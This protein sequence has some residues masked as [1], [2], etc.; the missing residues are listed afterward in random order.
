MAVETRSM[1]GRIVREKDGETVASGWCLIC[2]DTG[3]RG[4]PLDD[5]RGEMGCWDAEAR[6]TL[7]GLEGQT[8]YLHL[9]AYAGEFEPWHGPITAGL[10]GEDLDPDRRR[11]TLTPAGTL[12]RSLYYQPSDDAEV[13]DA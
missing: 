10:V 3:E 12:T 1:P 2:F 6:Q 13:A 7:V 4:R 11:I 5:W 8:L 9:D